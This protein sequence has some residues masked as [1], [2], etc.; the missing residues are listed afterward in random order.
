M[1]K[2][3]VRA[4]YFVMYSLLCN[5][6]KS[7]VKSYITDNAFGLEF[8]IP[9]RRGVKRGGVGEYAVLLEVHRG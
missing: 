3:F 6:T 7:S 8:L 4:F 2:G 5:H 9:S 1:L